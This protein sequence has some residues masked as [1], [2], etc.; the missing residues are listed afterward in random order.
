MRLRWDHHRRPIGRGGSGDPLSRPQAR[1]LRHLLD[2]RPVRSAE[3][4]LIR[5]LVIEVD[6]A[7]LGPQ[8]VGDL[9]RD[10][11]EDLFEVE[12][13]VHRGDRLGEKAQMA[14][15]YVHWGT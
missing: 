5:A 4:E 2:A 13:R 6:E 12:R 8:G 9:A 15:P 11:L 10:E 1:A 7:G 3:N 14:S